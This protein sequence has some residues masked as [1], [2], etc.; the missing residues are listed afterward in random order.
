MGGHR[1]LKGGRFFRLK[2]EKRRLHRES[3]EGANSSGGAQKQ[4]CDSAGIFRHHRFDRSCV[5]NHISQHLEDTIA[6]L[7]KEMKKERETPPVALLDGEE[8]S[9][10][11]HVQRGRQLT[12]PCVIAIA[13]ALLRRFA[14]DP[15][16]RRSAIFCIL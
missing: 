2:M 11:T 5:P 4:S 13:P 12:A 1:V 15:L 6:T 9:Q 8:R 10:T 3:C 16:E 14:S 7:N